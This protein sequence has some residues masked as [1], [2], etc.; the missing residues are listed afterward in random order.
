MILGLVCVGASGWL[1]HGLATPV[2]GRL[3]GVRELSFVEGSQ[4]EGGISPVCGCEDPPVDSWRGVGFAGRQVSLQHRGSPWTQWTISLAVPEPVSLTGDIKLMLAHAYRLRA[5]GPFDPS[6]LRNPESAKHFR[7][8]DRTRV[9]A[10]AFSM[11]TPREPAGQHV[12]R[13][14]DRC[15]DPLSGVASPAHGRAFPVLR[16]SSAATLDRELP[17]WVGFWSDRKGEPHPRE[18]QIYPIGDFL[19]PDLVL[20][21]NNPGARVIGTPFSGPAGPGV[22]TAVVVQ[23]S[24]FSTRIGVTGLRSDQVPVIEELTMDGPDRDAERTFDSANTTGTVSLTVKKPLSARQYRAV[25]RRVRGRPRRWVD[26]PPNREHGGDKF[27]KRGFTQEQ[28]YPPLPD[29][30]GF[31]VF[32]PLEQIAFRGVY[33]HLTVGDDHVDLRGSGDVVLS[34]VDDFRDDQRRQLISAPLATSKDSAQLQFGAQGTV[35]VNGNEQA[36]AQSKYKTPLKALGFVSSL[37]AALFGIVNGLRIAT[38]RR[39]QARP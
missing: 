13:C 34:D 10:Y 27:L 16:R 12:R 14:P 38:E 7:I 9:E 1:S 32:G 11:A 18:P 37:I 29:Y 36:T 22:I 17:P 23:P 20:W 8:L 4:D 5:H 19:G 3:A 39:R 31:N 21:S 24:I 26:V 15:L 30:A 2:N 35:T 6:Y 28:H 33:G 25:Q